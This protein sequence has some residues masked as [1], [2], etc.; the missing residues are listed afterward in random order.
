MAH[1]HEISEIDGGIII[2]QLR[3]GKRQRD[4]AL[5][6]GVSQSAVSRIKTK[7]ANH[8]TVKN[9]PRTRRPRVTSGREDRMLARF[10]QQEIYNW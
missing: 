3:A 4:I 7:F 10:A 9:L 8:Q 2:G 6:M 5:N 1:Q